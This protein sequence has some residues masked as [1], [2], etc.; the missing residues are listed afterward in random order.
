MGPGF[1]GT[2]NTVSPRGKGMSPGAF[3]DMVRAEQRT[4]NAN[5]PS[6]WRT[7]MWE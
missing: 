1:P 3:R 4:K 6:Q 2:S 5:S 7:E